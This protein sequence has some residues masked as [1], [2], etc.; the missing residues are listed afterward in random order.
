MV[1]PDELD[2]DN[3]KTAV[4][5][6]GVAWSENNTKTRYWTWGHI[7]EFASMEETLYPGDFLGS[8]TVGKGCG[9]ELGKLLNPGDIVELEIERIG[10]LKNII[11]EKPS[12]KRIFTR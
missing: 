8:G 6:N 5:I 7:I 11:G 2:P 10:I 1:T 12:V 4:R 3:L 9:I